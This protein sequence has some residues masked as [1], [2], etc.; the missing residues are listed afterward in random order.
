MP[1]FKLEHSKLVH[2][3]DIAFYV[4]GVLVL[5]VWLGLSAPQNCVW[6]ACCWP[7]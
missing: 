3:T 4:V 2:R 1:L 7:R 6:N 5:A